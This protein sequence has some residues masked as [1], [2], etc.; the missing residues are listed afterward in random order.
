MPEALQVAC[1]PYPSK[2]LLLRDQENR[3]LSPADLN[4][5]AREKV[6]DCLRGLVGQRIEGVPCILLI[7]C[8]FDMAAAGK[9]NGLAML[10]SEWTLNAH[11]VAALGFDAV[12]AGHYHRA[13]LL[14]EEPWIAYSGSPEATSFGE[15]TEAKSYFLLD[16]G[17]EGLRTVETIPTPYRQLVTLTE[18]DFIDP[19]SLV[20][21]VIPVGAIVR[22]DIPA[23]STLTIDEAKR[24]IEAAGAFEVRVTKA[25]AESV[26]RRETAVTSEMNST[27]ALREW[28]AQKPD[29]HPLTDALIVEAL[30]VEE[31]M[32]G[33]G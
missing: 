11:E 24:A 19:A 3:N 29:L 26:R 14:H 13:Q 23:S 20:A 22:F 15:E 18:A 8:A 12:C 27:D 7:H 2:N 33:V 10:T 32:G 30:R 21:G 28:L 25:R 31:A 4:L 5:L 1:F 6:M 16:V 9:Q 17:P